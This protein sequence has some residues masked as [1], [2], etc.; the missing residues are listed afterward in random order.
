MA[1]LRKAAHEFI[2]FCF[3]Y[4]WM[5]YV[6]MIWTWYLTNMIYRLAK[7]PAELIKPSQERK[8]LKFFESALFK[9]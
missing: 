1:F 2:W 7:Q 9:H 8:F 4:T 5:E 6:C 3:M